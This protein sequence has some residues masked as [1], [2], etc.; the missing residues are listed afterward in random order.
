MTHARPLSLALAAAAL[1]LACSPQGGQAASHDPLQASFEAT[2][3]KYQVPVEV[4]KAISYLETRWHQMPGVVSLD[5]GYGL[6]H[7]RASDGAMPTLMR[8]KLLTGLDETT[9]EN[10]ADANI[11]GGAAVLQ[12]L[13]QETSAVDHGGDQGWQ[14]VASWF[15]AVA[16]YGGGEQ[17]PEA[18]RRY[19]QSVFEILMNGAH[20]IDPSTSDLSMP[21]QTILLPPGE[22][23]GE[24]QAYATPDYPSARWIPASSANYTSASRPGSNGIHYLIIHD[25]EGSYDSAISWFGNPASQVSAHYVV[26]SSDGQVTQMV[27]DK[28]IAWHA[29]CWWMNENSIGIEHEGFMSQAGWYTDAMYR[30]SASLAR[31]LVNK[32]G[33]PVDRQHIVGHS[34]LYD[35]TDYTGT[36]ECAWVPSGERHWDPGPNWNWPVYMAYIQGASPPST[37]GGS[38]GGSCPNGDGLYCGGDGVSGNRNTLY[39]CSGGALS[40][41]QNCASGCQY[42][43]AGVADKCDPAPP[44]P[45]C[46]GGNGV[47]CGGDGVAGDRNTLYECSAGRLTV[48]Q[49]CSA[50][51]EFMPAGIPDR[52]KPASCPAG[53]GLYCG[54]DGVPGS[55]KV[56][57]QCTAGVLTEKESCQY[58]CESMPAGTADRCK[59]APTPPLCPDGDGLYCG[60]DGIPGD[61]GTLYQC[62]SGRLTVAQAC[63]AGCTREPAGIPD[64]CADSCPDGDGLYCGGN[65]VSGDTNTLYQCSA[66]RLTPVQVCSAGCQR[67]PSNVPDKCAPSTTSSACPQG[68]GLYCGGD[69]V[70]GNPGT[71]YSC[72]NGQLVV[73]QQCSSGCQKNPPGVPDACAP[74]STGGGTSGGTGGGTAGGSTSGSTGGSG[75]PGGKPKAKGL[76]VWYFDYT[77]L[78]AAQV[79]QDAQNDGVG[80]VLIKSGQDGS[81]WSDRYNASVV[82]EFTSRGM[83]VYAWPYV[84][85]AGVAGG[86]VSA[87]VQAAQVPG[88]TGVVFDVEAEF[89]GSSAS[90]YAS[91]AQQ[92]CQ[93]IRRQAPAGAFVGYTSFG[94]VG[95]HGTFPFATFDNYCNDGFFPQIYWA[96]RGVTPGYGFSQALQMISQANLRS[97]VWPIQSNDTG[98][99]ST[100]ELN[101]FFSMSGAWSSLW[102]FPGTSWPNYSAQVTQLASLNW[103]NP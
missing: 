102:E 24:S 57:F 84:T 96:D 43:P 59:P 53:D 1:A 58:G 14:D 101:L 56:L 88:T 7:L 36:K 72:H 67:E 17:N 28:D 29:G 30:S 34:E 20:A 52:C 97:F 95:Y 80:F 77:G 98:D 38:G 55:A 47:Y 54:G 3:Q 70:S 71:L 5:N 32:Y 44:P 37:P 62:T 42:M 79:A 9:L 2:S 48:L 13:Y 15:D 64:R 76:W 93:G 63:G 91:Q 23:V 100:A 35:L 75:T 60:G 83:K 61:P 4:L 94:W 78:S 41:V 87:A 69:G 92:L 33:I 51:C 65:G 85:P 25:T 11:Q 68:D 16:R 26:R 18:G 103:A 12:A 39:R 19:A 46:P 74:S 50:G 45:A 66:G 99:P 40:V 89:E 81:F 6:M 49:S 90:T 73:A 10:D 86:A 22:M 8:A 31:F 27:Q 82:S 21:P